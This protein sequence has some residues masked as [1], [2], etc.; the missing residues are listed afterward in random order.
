MKKIIFLFLCISNFC[1]AQEMQQGFTFLETGKYAEAELFFSK[2]LKEFP[3][4]KT[5]KLCYGRAV[6]LNG[7][8]EKAVVIFTEML[9]TYP[10]DF[11][12]ELNYAES[13]LWSKQFEKAETYYKTLVSKNSTSF[14]ALLGFANTLSNL[15]KYDG[16]LDYVNKALDVIPGNPNAMVSKKYIYLGMANQQVQNQK[17]DEAIATLLTDLELFPNDKDILLNLGNT[18]IIAKK[19]NDATETYNSMLQNS[20]LYFTAKNNLALIAHLQEKDKKALQISSKTLTEIT[21]STSVKDKKGTQERHAQALIW[22]AKYKDAKKYIEEIAVGKEN[23][24]WILGLKAT[25]YTYTGDF[26]NSLL[27]YNLIL[28]ND[29]A[30]FDGNLGKAN[31]LK[32]N[33][34]IKEALNAAETTLQHFPKQK[35]AEN[36]IKQIKISYLPTLDTKISHSYDIGESKNN[37]YELA[38]TLPVS[39]K[40]SILTSFNQKS[41]KNETTDNES[42]SET[43]SFGLAYQLL[44][45]VN[46]TGNIGINRVEGSVKGEKTEYDQTSAL[47][48]FKTTPFKRQILDFGYKRATQ[49]FNAELLNREIVLNDLFANYNLNTTFNLG[50]FTQYFYTFQSDSNKR[51]LLFTSLYY[52][53][54]KKPAIKTGINFQYLTYAVQKPDIYFS[55]SAFKS[56]ELFINLIKDKASAKNKEF[57][58]GF[59]GA[60]GYQYT[61][62]DP[63]TAAYR[64][65]ANL[66]Y[67][68]NDYAILDTYYTFSNIAAAAV[69]ENDKG[70]EY[71]EFG[72]KFTWKFLEKPLFKSLQ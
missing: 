50:W 15:K 13:L 24:S 62:K 5:A 67:K 11:E 32:A 69:I 48:L 39:I 43:M 46:V 54:V 22:N 33:N 4:N 7:N 40:T 19:Y 23:E 47:L 29:I 35:D 37:T 68:F 41:G 14:A 18:Y 49:N 2:V 21:S 65:Q 28:E 70:F 56:V 20:S 58:Y 30:S 17:Y 64:I 45:K 63:K 1:F 8:A 51:H 52:N 31:A 34:K 59:T 25:L 55:P 12:I 61:E 42:T 57:F 36:F 72:L 66:G 10:G 60:Y 6:G 16:A 27:Q 38:L 9:Q 44:P 53:L 71:T 26:K 3:T